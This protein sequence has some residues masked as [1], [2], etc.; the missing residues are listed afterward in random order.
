MR[1]FSARSLDLRESLR[2][3]EFVVIVGM[4]EAVCFRSLTSV[5]S[6]PIAQ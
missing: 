4:G 2:L 1:M 6:G 3:R 5:L